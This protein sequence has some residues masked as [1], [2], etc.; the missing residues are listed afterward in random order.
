MSPAAT[1]RADGR[2]AGARPTAASPTRSTRATMTADVV[3]VGGGATGVGI[4]RDAAM[5]GLSVILLERAD[6]AQGTSGRFHGL[7]HSGGRYVVSDPQSATEC[8]EENEIVS[9]IHSAAVEKVGGLFVVTPEDDLAFSEKF[10]AGAKAT[11]VPAEEISLS[12]ALRI[13]PRLNPGIKRAFRVHDGAVDGWQM[14]WGAAHSAEEYGAKILT[15]HEVTAV[16][17]EEISTDDG[18]PAAASGGATP[19]RRVVGVQARGVKTGEEITISCRMLMNAAGPWGGRI[20]EMAG[21]HSVKIAAGRGVMVAMNHR[22]VNHVVNRCVHPSDGDIIVPDHTVSIIGTTDRRAEDPDHLAIPREEVA[23]MLDAGEVLIPGFRQARALHAWSGARPLVLDTSVAADDTRHMSRG[24]TVL[25]HARVDG[26][27]GMITVAGGKLTTYRLMAQHAVDAMC[28]EMGV[29]TPCRTAEEEVPGSKGEPNYHITHRLGEREAHRLTDP[30]IC[31]CEMVGRQAI[32][33]LM[34]AQPDASF[35]DLRRQLRV[36]MGPCQGGFCAPRVAGLHACHGYSAADASEALKTFL[37]H[38]WIGLWTIL[39]GEQVR[40]T[41]LDF[42]ML[43]GSLDIEDLPDAPAPAAIAT[44]L[45]G[46]ENGVASEE[47]LAAATGALAQAPA[48]AADQTQ[49]T[50]QAEEVLA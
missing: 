50:T 19:S 49:P 38:R 44:A 23:Q 10:I 37:R 7:L 26:L 17:T 6:L 12:E 41:A 18:V 45:D 33:D 4:A 31:E 29:T 40:E 3:V 24:M 25:S 16:L 34:K 11:G 36:A 39:H 43:Q 5:R 21:S 2:S 47:E 20:A 13:E 1:R 8:A 32:V 15:Y 35:D 46:V 22:L 28:E 30:T 9:R 27:A 48:V 14:V 42:W